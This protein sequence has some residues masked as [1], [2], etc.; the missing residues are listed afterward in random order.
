ISRHELTKC[1]LRASASGFHSGVISLLDLDA[2]GGSVDVGVIVVQRGTKIEGMTLSATPYKAPK[3]ARR[4][5][6]KGL[7]AE[8][9]GKLADARKYFETAVALYPSS[10]NA[11]FRLGTVLQKEK[12]KDAARQ[13]YTQ[14]TTID[15][16][17]L[18]PS[19]SIA[20][21]QTC[22]AVAPQAK[23]ADQAREQLAKL[24]KLN[25]SVSTSEKPDQR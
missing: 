15:T 6:E 18:Q 25:G 7:Q 9:N 23:D 11:W 4:A 14:A 24:E 16:T 21:M 12:Q 2:F 10:A 20:E 3:D 8:R 13:A 17:F 1:E 19:L 22:V 5:Y